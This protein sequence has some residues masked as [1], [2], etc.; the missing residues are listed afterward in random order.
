MSNKQW[1]LVV[2]FMFEVIYKLNR[3]NGGFH[4]STEADGLEYE[5]QVER[6]KMWFPTD[7]DEE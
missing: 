4:K 3:M 1:S 7:E 6:D 2:R 5:L